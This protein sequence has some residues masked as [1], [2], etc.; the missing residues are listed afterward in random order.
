ML[1]IYAGNNPINAYDYLGLEVRMMDALKSTVGIV[2]NA[3]GVATGVGMMGA[4]TGVTQVVGAALTAKSAYGVA[5]NVVNLSNAI[6]GKDPASTGGVFTD[7]AAAVAPDN[8]TVQNLAA[9]TDLAVDLACGQIGKASAS[10]PVS[11]SAG[12]SLSESGAK[13]P[14]LD[15]QMADPTNLGVVAEVFQGAAV[16][17]AGVEVTQQIKEA[18]VEAPPPPPDLQKLNDNVH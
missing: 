8:Q 9:A 18:V 12:Y 5:A 7:A 6:Q 10:Q 11:M 15:S 14:L 13:V 3:A 1:Y 4:P 17:V 16:V 2:S